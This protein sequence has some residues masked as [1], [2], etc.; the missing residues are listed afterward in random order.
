MAPVALNVATALA[1]LDDAVDRCMTENVNTPEV[2]AALD[3]LGAQTTV[4]WPFE[5][6][7][8][9]LAPKEGEFD[10]DKEGRRQ[11]LNAS[12]NGIKRAV[13]P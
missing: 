2:L 1:T 11:V 3:F 4:K 9:A 13:K 5:Q 12:L 10:F 6:Y 7:R 8:K